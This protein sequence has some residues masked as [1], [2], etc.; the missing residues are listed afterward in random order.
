[1]E[2]SLRSSVK[3]SEQ[4]SAKRLAIDRSYLG[5]KNTET[6][7]DRRQSLK[8]NPNSRQNRQV[9]TNSTSSHL[10]DRDYFMNVTPNFVIGIDV[11]KKSFDTFVH[12]EENFFS[13]DYDVAG[14]E[15]LLERLPEP[16]QC[17]IVMESTG[18]YERRLVAE[19][20]E[21]GYR[22]AVVNARLVRDYAKSRGILAK[23]DRIDAKVIAQYGEHIKPRSLEKPRENQD[24]LG[25]LVTRRRQLIGLRTS[26]TNRLETI[27]S[28][29]VQKSILKMVDQL[30]KQIQQIEAE[31]A[32]LIE[33][34]EEWSRKASLIKSVPGVGDVTAVSLLAEFPELGQL[35]RQEAA[36]LAGLAPFNRD[37]G[38]FRGRRSIY[39]G[40]SSI[41]KCLYMAALVAKRYNPTIRKFAQRLEKAGKPFKVVIT[42]CMR[43]LLVILN[44]MM[45]T[46][47]HW[48][49]K[50]AT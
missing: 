10:Q 50:N 27:T 33:T 17:L 36:A 35:G 43:K 37:S 19:L 7:R 6:Q 45:K 40:R 16:S 46:N 39:G 25:Q 49:Q 38:A 30:K 20:I 24:E 29:R 47:T 8:F 32:N 9:N 5:A 15:Q 2:T 12:P 13:L 34:D 42:A 23:T 4:D 48:N 22:V 1:M 28:K 11:A 3:R 44:S 18:G 14:L 26:E 31:I 41:R 21:G